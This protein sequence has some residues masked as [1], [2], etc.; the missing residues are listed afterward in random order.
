MNILREDH[1]SKLPQDLIE[2]A[3]EMSKA[4]EYIYCIENSIRLFLL[5][6]LPTEFTLPTSV[7][8]SIEK[9][10]E[11]ELR[12]RWMPLRGTS[13]L[14]YADFTDLNGIIAMNWDNLKESFPDQVW[15]SAKLADLARYRN[16]IAH[17]SYLEKADFDMVKAYFNS[18]S[19]QIGLVQMNQLVKLAN[20]YSAGFVMGLQNNKVYMQEEII[21]GISHQLS[22][23]LDIAVQPLALETSFE[24]FFSIFQV[25]FESAKVHLL[26]DFKDLEYDDIMMNPRYDGSIQFEIGQYDID[27]DGLDEIFICVRQYGEHHE[28]I[29]IVNVFKYYPPFFKSH[30]FR[31]ENWELLGTFSTGCIMDEPIVQLRNQSIFI[32]RNFNHYFD[33]W[34]YVNGEFL[35]QGI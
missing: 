28:S 33:E 6:K 11:E 29:V 24:R 22:Y 15:I 8:K 26:L 25:V 19:R 18:I 21:S 9:R 17:N 10:K 35:H 12:H 3:L 14:Y 31:N 1:L 13:D 27:G 5:S 32:S 20:V 2:K 30:A 4:Y 34:T 23:P 16:M 7:Q